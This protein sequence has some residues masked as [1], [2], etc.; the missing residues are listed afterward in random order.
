VLRPGF[1]LP[2]LMFSADEIEALVLG[3]RWVA[4]RG[5]ARLGAAADNA[6]SKIRS[7]LVYTFMRDTRQHHRF[8]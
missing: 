8:D 5:D 7:L 1:T 3:S 6:V 2:P 4:M